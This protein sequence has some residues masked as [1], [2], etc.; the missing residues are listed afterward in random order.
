MLGGYEYFIK[1]GNSAN[2]NTIIGNGTYD[3]VVE[4]KAFIFI[5]SFATNNQI[6]AGYWDTPLFWETNGDRTY[7]K[8]RNSIYMNNTSDTTT[9]GSSF[10]VGG[11]S[12]FRKSAFVRE[13][14]TVNHISPFNLRLQ[15]QFLTNYFDVNVSDASLFSISS[16]ENAS[17]FKV[18]KS[19]LSNSLFI[20]NFGGVLFNRTAY[21]NNAG[22][23]IHPEGRAIFKQSVYI[24][25]NWDGSNS[26]KLKVNG[27]S[28][29]A[30]PVEITTTSGG[31][32]MPRLTTAQRNAIGS[33]P[34]GLTL[35]CTDCTATDASTG[36]MQVWNGSTWKSCW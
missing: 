10:Y 29:L 19:A 31:V 4:T 5:D 33:P 17:I 28:L 36:V 8:D 25:Y 21:N 23:Y 6:F 16:N 1:L 30:G 7:I 24:D 2:A 14:L 20:D 9:F 32:L 15:P 27:T 26:Y 13:G 3:P 12:V 35:F 11:H 34:A 18:H 22:S